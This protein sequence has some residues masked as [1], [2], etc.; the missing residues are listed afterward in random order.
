[1]SNLELTDMIQNNIDFFQQLRKTFVSCPCCGHVYRL[2]DS[3]IFNGSKPN[4]DWKIRLEEEYQKI[5][6][7]EEALKSKIS[8]LKA[9][10][11]DLGRSLAVTQV[12]TYDTVFK[13][14]GLEPI[15]CKNI[16]HPVDF[17]VFNGMHSGKIK[18]LVFL[19]RKTNTPI[20]NSIRDCIE[21]EQ[22]TWKT[23]RINTTGELK[24]E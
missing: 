19:D 5:S 9:E 8:K 18:N 22:Y 1:M 11:K 6:K 16:C 21:N 4:K 23:I 17:I 3:H 20:Q 7:R 15:D 12:G 2:S 10:A 14:L 24:E 13:P